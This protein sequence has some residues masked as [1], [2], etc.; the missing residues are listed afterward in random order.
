MCGAREGAGGSC[1]IEILYYAAFV[2]MMMMM[3]RTLRPA[4]PP[5]GSSVR[6]TAIVAL[7]WNLVRRGWR[8]RD[9]APSSGV[10]T[11]P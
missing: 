5:R 4:R 6:W 11:R 7:E 8:S 3:L 2:M 1:S 9:G 10:M